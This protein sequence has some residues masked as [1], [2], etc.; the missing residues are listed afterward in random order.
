LNPS[1]AATLAAAETTNSKAHDLFLAGREFLHAPTRNRETY[2]RSVDIFTKAIAEDPDYG[3]PYAGLAFAQIHNWQHHWTDDWG[4]ALESAEKNISVALG[5]S[6]RVAYAHY[7]A[8]IIYFWKKDLDRS[9][10]EGDM[11][12]KLN[13]N[14]AA[15]LCTRG[16]V[17]VYAGQP[18]A[19]VP[20]IE[21]AFLLDPASKQLYLHFLGS[22]YLLAG[23]YKTAASVFRERKQTRPED[24][25]LPRF[26]RRRARPPR[27]GRGSAAGLA[28]VEGDQPKIFFPRAP[29][30]PAV[31]QPSGSRPSDGG[32]DQGRHRRFLELT[33]AAEYSRR[34][35]AAFY[36]LVNAIGTPR[37]ERCAI[38]S[39]LEGRQSARLGRPAASPERPL[40]SWSDE[41]LNGDS[42]REGDGSSRR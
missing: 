12:L 38:R 7:V 41:R 13:P 33:Q 30:P 5:K 3:E 10:A 27:R 9:A 37:N 19:A 24:G 25:S 11:A 16:L 34:A 17:S 40:R 36:C 29:R 15:A 18:L 1:E 39:T 42:G 20:Y 32:T 2:D 8:E 35:D 26:S 14:H 6:P 22:A 21:R 4:Q 23:D 28:R 31:P